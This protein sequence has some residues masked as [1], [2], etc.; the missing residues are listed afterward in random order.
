MN[1]LSRIVGFG[2][3]LSTVVLG[4]WTSAGPAFI[5]FPSLI[6]IIGI[7]TGGL[8]LSFCPS[9]VLRALG[10]GMGLAQ[11]RSPEELKLDIMIFDRAR[12]L[13][14]AGGFLASLI[15]FIAMMSLETI[16]LAGCAIATLNL[17]YGVILAEV[18]FTPLKHAMIARS[19]GDRRNH[20]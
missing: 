8:F 11:A 3:L 12:Q 2:I 1:A 14:W 5:H 4:A 15:G 6:F 10:R 17:F 19:L 18:I 7:L 9:I 13:A 20:G 16:P